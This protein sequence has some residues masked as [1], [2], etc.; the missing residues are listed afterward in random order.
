MEGGAF[1]IFRETFIYRMT[2][3]GWFF[4][5][6]WDTECMGAVAGAIV[7]TVV[8]KCPLHRI[9]FAVQRHNEVTVLWCRG[10][11]P[12]LGGRGP[13]VNDAPRLGPAAPAARHTPAPSPPEPVL[14]V[15]YRHL[16]LVYTEHLLAYLLNIL[17][18]LHSAII[19]KNINYWWRWVQ[20]KRV[21]SQQTT[22]SNI[23]LKVKPDKVCSLHFCTEWNDWLH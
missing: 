9:W 8:K 1:K 18:A 12:G 23:L 19:K 15:A 4:I 6:V 22:L 7:R 5:V 16:Y 13:Q 17:L 11:R 20:V 14:H 10:P 21:T 2:A 3:C